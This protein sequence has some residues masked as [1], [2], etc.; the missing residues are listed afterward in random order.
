MVQQTAGDIKLFAKDIE[1]YLIT[2]GLDSDERGEV[3]AYMTELN[4]A[5]Q[6]P[7]DSPAPRIVDG[8]Y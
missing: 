4:S 5:V 8:W 1:A 3:K 7:V 6:T 2:L